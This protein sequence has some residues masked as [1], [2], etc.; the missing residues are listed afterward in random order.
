MPAL[1][2]R[3]SVRQASKCRCGAT[4][5]LR[6]H[7]THCKKKNRAPING[8]LF[9]I[10]MYAPPLAWRPLNASPPSEMPTRSLEAHHGWVLYHD[11]QGYPYYHNAATGESVWAAHSVNPN[12]ERTT[13]DVTTVIIPEKR[14]DSATGPYS[15]RAQGSVVPADIDDHEVR[16]SAHVGTDFPCAQDVARLYPDQPNVGT[17]QHTSPYLSV[18]EN[19]VQASGKLSDS[20]SD[21]NQ[22]S[23]DDSDDAA[24][25]D[26]DDDNDAEVRE[27]F[28]AMLATPEG[29][30]AL[31]AEMRRV[32]ELMER[33]R[34]QD[35]ESWRR[36][37][38]SPFPSYTTRT[39]PHAALMMQRLIIVPMLLLQ[40]KCN[41]S[42]SDLLL[43]GL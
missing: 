35:Y 6:S 8:R 10:M 5:P 34:H 43:C 13:H 42:K 27:K 23:S 17:N 22:E 38:G 26:D 12:D 30:A 40:R 20:D 16:H 36:S 31:Q 29:Q 4:Q 14:S 32:E 7:S 37:S 1:T 11:S 15:T 33:K 21:E 28:S 3:T 2:V 18:D 19:S 41:A 9:A 25:L 24:F 39:E